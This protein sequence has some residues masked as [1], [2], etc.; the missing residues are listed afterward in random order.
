M[1]WSGPK[2]RA[3]PRVHDARVSVSANGV[4]AHAGQH[5]PSLHAADGP[6]SIRSRSRLTPGSG[7]GSLPSI[8]AWDRA[9]FSS[10]TCHS[11]PASARTWRRG[12]VWSGSQITRVG[13]PTRTES[14]DGRAARAGGVAAAARAESVLRHHSPVVVA[15]RPDDSRGATSEAVSAFTPSVCTA[16]T[17][18]RRT[19]TARTQ[20]GAPVFRTVSRRCELTRRS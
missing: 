1:P 5:C 6:A 2:W 7:R 16:T 10:G 4:P 19:I 9:T 17:S 13:L 18:A 14:A 12:R 3:S 15:R 8:A 11:A 20:A